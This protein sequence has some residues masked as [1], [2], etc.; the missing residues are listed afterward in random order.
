MNIQ[1]ARGS[2]ERR[3]SGGACDGGQRPLAIFGHQSTDGA[4][5]KV[6]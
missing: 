5:P 3:G 2:G 4:Q 1:G 6:P